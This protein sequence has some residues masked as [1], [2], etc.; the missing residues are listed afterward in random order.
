MRRSLLSIALILSLVVSPIGSIAHPFQHYGESDP[1][2]PAHESGTP[3]GLCTAFVALECEAGGAQSLPLFV[4]TA[5][6]ASS[7]CATIV[8]ARGFRYFFQRGPPANL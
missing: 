3:C 1:L 6:A 7:E 2:H 4:G 5:T 8:V